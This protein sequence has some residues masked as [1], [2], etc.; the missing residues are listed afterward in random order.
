MSLNLNE[1][2]IVCYTIFNIP[3][4]VGYNVA[5]TFRRSVLVPSLAVDTL[6]MEPESSSKTYNLNGV[7]PEDRNPDHF[8][9]AHYTSF[10][11]I[12]NTVFIR[13]IV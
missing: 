12:Q 8:A 11:K 3:S 2:H 4:R 13:S 7:I 1:L 9:H 5:Y 10:F 6:K